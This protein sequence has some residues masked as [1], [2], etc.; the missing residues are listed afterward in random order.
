MTVL[1]IFAPTEENKIDKVWPKSLSSSHA[2]VAKMVVT[3]TVMVVVTMTVKKELSQD[4]F[5]EN[6]LR[7]R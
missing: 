4:R 1:D 6:I 2:L 7:V 3:V 5:D